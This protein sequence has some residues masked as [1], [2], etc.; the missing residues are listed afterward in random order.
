MPLANDSEPHQ[1]CDQRGVSL[2]EV[3]VTVL[4]LAVGLLGVA[5]MQTFGV[6]LVRDAGLM[7][8]ASYMASNMADKMRSNLSAASQYDGVDG[9]DTRCLTPNPSAS[10]PIP[11]CSAAQRDL[12]AWNEAIRRVLPASQGSVESAGNIHRITVSWRESA[13]STQDDSERDYTLVVRL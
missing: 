9:T 8:Q 7:T 13:D 11:A 2:I 6:R 3:M 4:V 1:R 10:P 12:I 5:S